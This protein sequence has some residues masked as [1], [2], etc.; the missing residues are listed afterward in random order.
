MQVLG[1]AAGWSAGIG[2]RCAGLGGRIEYV[3]AVPAGRRITHN[4]LQC[5]IIDQPGINAIDKRIASGYLR[6]PIR[7]GESGTG[8]VYRVDS[9]GSRSGSIIGANFKKYFPSRVHYYSAAVLCDP[10]AV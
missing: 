10:L 7:Q 1:V 9:A 2:L 5:R 8:Q 6:S 4:A 3:D